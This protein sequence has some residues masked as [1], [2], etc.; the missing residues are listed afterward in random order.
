M[1]DTCPICDG[2]I[3][4]EVFDDGSE[5]F[6]GA[7]ATYI[8]RCPSCRIS[9]QPAQYWALHLVPE[10]EEIAKRIAVMDFMRRAKA[11]KRSG[12]TPLHVE[13]V[14]YISVLTL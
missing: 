6:W 12:V 13:M 4:A 10:D 1:P 3:S 8:A 14:S 11:M 7:T 9:G 5:P 2:M